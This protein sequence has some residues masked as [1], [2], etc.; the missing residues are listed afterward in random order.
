MPR[1]NSQSVRS[2]RPPQK[3]H[4][5]RIASLHEDETYKYPEQETCVSLPEV[6]ERDLDGMMEVDFWPERKL[7][8]WDELVGEIVQ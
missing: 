2:T 3:R 8:V 4:L 5:I 6:D 1:K 7:S